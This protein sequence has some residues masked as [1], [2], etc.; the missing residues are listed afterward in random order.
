MIF[1]AVGISHWKSEV[2]IRELF[3]LDEHRKNLLEKYTQHIPGGVIMLDT[4]NRTEL[5]AFCD[6]EILISA[7]C[8]STNTTKDFFKKHGYSYTDTEAY[9]HLYGVGVGLDSQVLGDVQIIQQ[10][11]KSYRIAKKKG[12]SGEFHQLMQ[13]VFKA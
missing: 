3:Y 8:N 7:L 4:C 1:S 9:D 5:Y 6:P 10:V 11:K 13:S 12:L 2:S